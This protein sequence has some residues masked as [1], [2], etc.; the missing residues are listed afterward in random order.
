M[1]I[2]HNIGPFNNNRFKWA[3]LN[4]GTLTN[5]FFGTALL[6]SVVY[7]QKL[8]IVFLTKTFWV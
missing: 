7:T 4:I 5:Y 2:D 3:L 1:L 8:N 6:I